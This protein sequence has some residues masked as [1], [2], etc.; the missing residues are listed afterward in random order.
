[1][2][3]IAEQYGKDY[4]IDNEDDLDAYLKEKGFKSLARLLQ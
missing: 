3:D 4:G 1:M 2:K